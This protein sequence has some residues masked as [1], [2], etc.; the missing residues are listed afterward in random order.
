MMLCVVALLSL[1]L[2]VGEDPAGAADNVEPAPAVSAPA[3]DPAPTEPAPT[4]PAAT[5][6]APTEPAPTAPAPTAPLAIEALPAVVDDADAEAAYQVCNALLHAPPDPAAAPDAIPA[7]RRLRD[8]F[9]SVVVQHRGTLAALKAD[10]AVVV[11]DATAKPPEEASLIPPGRLGITTAAGLFGVWNGVA[12]GAMT[13]LTI[14]DI[15]P[16][17]LVAGTGAAAVATGIGFG[18]GGYL[19]AEKLQLDEGAA[20]LVAS[21][22]VWST[23][24]GAGV[25]VAIGSAAA[26]SGFAPQL[27][28]ATV[29]GAGYVGA[30]ATLLLTQYM[31]FDEAQVAMINSG[32]IVGAALGIVVDAN[33]ASASAGQAS[34]TT[35]SL[36]FVGST[37]LGLGVGGLLGRRY[38]LTWGEALLCDLGLVLGGVIGGTGS[39]VFGLATGGVNVPVVTFLPLAGMVAGYGAGMFFVGQWRDGR[40]VPVLRGLPAVR[41][42]VSTLTTGRA[43]VPS[44]GVAGTF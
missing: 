16:T 17:G 8:C 14:P 11:L 15:N 3:T 40:G 28:L 34:P 21:S 23:V 39:I 13:A 20:R 27:S 18:I 6:P 31:S 32:G 19:I 36:A 26:D 29:V 33:L 42:I 38:A 30:G 24:L 41:P 7:E 35:L 43:V 25:S 4:E 44:V 2:V 22:L 5:E 12:G 37:A 1:P 9:S 10:V